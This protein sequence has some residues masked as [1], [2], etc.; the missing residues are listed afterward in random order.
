M[1]N[2]RDC[3]LHLKDLGVLKGHPLQGMSAAVTVDGGLF[4][5]RGPVAMGNRQLF[6]PFPVQESLEESL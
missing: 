4:T 5:F 3:G 1:F 2:E 6:Y